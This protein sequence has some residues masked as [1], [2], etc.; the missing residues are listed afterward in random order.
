MMSK[1][2]ALSLVHLSTKGGHREDYLRLLSEALGLQ[3]SVGK[4]TART[5]IPLM[6]AKALLF[7]T[8][9]DDVRGFVLVALFRMMIGKK[10]AALFLRPQ[11][12]FH[13]AGVKTKIKHAIFSFFA[14]SRS[15]SVCTILPFEVSPRNQE[16]A[17][18]GLADPQL[19][20]REVLPFEP[21]A[22]FAQQLQH[23]AG[24]RRIMAFIGTASPFKGVAQLCEMMA[25]PKWDDSVCVVFAG[26][27]PDAV[28]PLIKRAEALGA[29]VFPR[30]VTNQELD[31]IYEVSDLIWAGYEPGY[32]Q[33]SGNFG[34]ALQSGKTPV[35]RKG[36]LIA[37]LAQLISYPVV[38][39]DFD[40][41]KPAITQFQGRS[42]ASLQAPKDSIARWEEEFRA[43]MVASL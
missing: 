2:R 13:P 16:V 27:V 24:R 1:Y 17:K 25:H 19:W 30:F 37:R 43:A 4:V 18:Y 21:C 26:R 32:D 31:A 40:D 7:G 36:T 23:A 29:I 34:R 22:E 3:P 38:T 15:V 20:D 28:L 5:F 11:S 41:L 39:V 8:L 35:V 6:G 10:T 9:D 33:A 14:K 12:C 42:V